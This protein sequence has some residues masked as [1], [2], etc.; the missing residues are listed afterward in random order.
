MWFFVVL[1]FQ[2]SFFLLFSWSPVLAISNNRTLVMLKIQVIFSLGV[3]DSTLW[4]TLLGTLKP[5]LQLRLF[6][7]E[8]CYSASALCTFIWE[9][10]KSERLL[11]RIWKACFSSVAWTHPVLSVK[12]DSWSHEIIHYTVKRNLFF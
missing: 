12:A 8:K 5:D 9:R 6:S 4:V 7:S 2:L 11:L 1:F 10:S 3:K